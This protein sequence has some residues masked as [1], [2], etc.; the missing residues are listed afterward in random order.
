[1]SIKDLYNML[2]RKVDFGIEGYNLVK[3][4]EDPDADRKNSKEYNKSRRFKELKR[5]SYLEDDFNSKKHIPG[6]G[7]YKLGTDFEK[8]RETGKIG[9]T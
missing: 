7:R 9:K 2:T 4:Y 6:V 8:R 3:K 1:M 5:G